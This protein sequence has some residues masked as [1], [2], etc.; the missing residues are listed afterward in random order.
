MV[1]H[2]N[3]Q[4]VKSAEDYSKALKNDDSAPQGSRISNNLGEALGQVPILKLGRVHEL[5]QQHDLYFKL[6]SCNPGGSIK[7][8]NASY[9][10]E[11]AEKM[12]LLKKGGTIIESSSGN[13]GIGLAMVGAAKDYRVK[14][15]VDEKTSPTMR[16]ILLALGAELVDVPLSQADEN[17]SM[18]IARM[19]VAASLTE[20][21]PGAWYPCQ[22]KNP[23]NPVAHTLYTAREIIAS[24]GRCPDAIVIGISTAGQLS[25][26]SSY[27]KTHYPTVK[28]IVVDVAGSCILG[29]PR[30]AYKMTGLGL[31]FIPPNFREDFCDVGYSVEDDLAFSLCRQIAKKEGLLLGGST[32]AILAGGLAYAQEQTK[33]KTI[34]MINPDR[35]DRYLETV[36]DDNWISNQGINLLEGEHLNARIDDLEPVLLFKQ[37]T[38]S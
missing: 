15:V 25:G 24:F 21:I 16:K 38:K 23:M 19:K 33:K 27:F 7:E 37:G 9:L 36:Y 1:A 28:I 22:H 34:L 3:Y 17:G 13:F 20:R 8:K 5:C 2:I 29:T 14:I 32:G 6:E 26:I 18:Q 4:Q 31:S 35:G 30:H 10:V 12:G 11:Q